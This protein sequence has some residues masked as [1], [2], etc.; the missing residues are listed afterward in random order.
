M[1]IFI[2]AEHD[3]ERTIFKNRTK[4]P[5]LAENWRGDASLRPE[6]LTGSW[7]RPTRYFRGRSGGEAAFTPV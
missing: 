5:V 7:A 1:T 3:P 6:L 2:D 4:H